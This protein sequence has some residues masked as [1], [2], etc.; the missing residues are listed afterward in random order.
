MMLGSILLI[1][2]SPIDN[3]INRIVLQGTNFKSEIIEFL[4]AGKALEYLKSLGSTEEI[5]SIIFLDINMPIM[6]GFLF[7][8][9]F[10]GLSDLIREKTKIVMLSSTLNPSEIEKVMANSHVIKFISKPLS[11]KKIGELLN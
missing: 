10:N 6:N 4:D 9:E 2:D 1:D 5:P 11:A 7:L 3:F 8:E